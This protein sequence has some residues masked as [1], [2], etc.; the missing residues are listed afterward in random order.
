M[1]KAATSLPARIA[2]HPPPMMTGGA[3]VEGFGRMVGNAEV[4]T[5]PIFSS[6]GLR[7]PRCIYSGSMTCPLSSRRRSKAPPPVDSVVCNRVWNQVGL[8]RF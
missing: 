7:L 2:A 4:T 6:C 1:L 8:C 3:F 5:L